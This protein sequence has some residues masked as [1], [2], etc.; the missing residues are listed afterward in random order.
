MVVQPVGFKRWLGGVLGD[1]RRRQPSALRCIIG[2]ATIVSL[3]NRI[4]RE[5]LP[6]AWHSHCGR[7]RWAVAT[8][9]AVVLVC[10]CLKSTST[11]VM[12]ALTVIF[13]QSLVAIGE[14]DVGLAR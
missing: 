3:S 12:A 14:V 8:T 4:C 13:S 11:H 2:T 6:R 1:D 7:V 5:P 9:E 10:Y